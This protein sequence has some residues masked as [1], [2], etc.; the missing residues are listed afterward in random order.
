MR[1]PASTPIAGTVLAGKKTGNSPKVTKK[2]G[3]IRCPPGLQPA[4]GSEK[5]M[6]PL[7]L[8]FD[9][10]KQIIGLHFV[11]LL[12]KDLGYLPGSRRVNGVFHFHRLD[13]H[14]FVVLVNRLTYLD[15][16]FMTFPGI[17]DK[18]STLTLLASCKISIYMIPMP[19]STESMTAAAI[20]EPICPPALAPIACIKR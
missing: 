13:P 12:D 7:S 2:S 20:T 6:F 14:N 1:I 16:T 18:S 4:P 3:V 17:G 5:S 11:V 9:D 15:K 8:I 19:L 10:Q